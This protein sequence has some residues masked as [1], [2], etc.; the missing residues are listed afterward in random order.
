ML[1][2]HC[3]W[4]KAVMTEKLCVDP[5]KLYEEAHVI[6]PERANSVASQAD[7]KECTICLSE[8]SPSV[9]VSVVFAEAKTIFNEEQHDKITASFAFC[10][11]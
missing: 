5:K 4:D 3:K 7:D 1:L 2:S 8:L 11:C 9:C 10:R 6:D